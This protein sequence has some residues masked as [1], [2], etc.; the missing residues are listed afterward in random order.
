MCAMGRTRKRAKT[1]PSEAGARRDMSIIKTVYAALH[2]P[3]WETTC[4]V[5]ESLEKRRVAV[6]KSVQA[7]TLAE[8]CN[9]P[10]PGVAEIACAY[11]QTRAALMAANTLI[12]EIATA[13]DTESELRAEY[14]KM[15]HGR[16]CGLVAMLRRKLAKLGDAIDCCSEGFAELEH[17]I[18]LQSD[19]AYAVLAVLPAHDCYVCLEPHTAG[20]TFCSWC[21]A[22]VCAGCVQGLVRGMLAAGS[23]AASNGEACMYV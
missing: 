13:A 11:R 3:A 20:L 19:S 2:H 15:E 21:S 5:L 17:I 6:L 10:P 16:L 9:S 14:Q 1:E 7:L 4:E 12:A 23:I 18:D 22:V 8:L